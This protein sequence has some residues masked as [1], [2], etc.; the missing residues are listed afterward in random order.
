MLSPS[1]ANGLIGWTNRPMPETIRALIVVLV[2]AVPAFYV[3]QQVSM[4]VVGPREFAIWGNAWFATTIVAFVTANFFIFAVYIVMLCV[5]LRVAKASSVGIYFLLLFAVPAVNISIGGFGIVNRLLDINNARLLSIVLLLPILLAASRSG[6]RSYALPDI[7]IVSYVLFVSILAVRNS[8]FTNV[9][10]VITVR[11]LDVL[12]PYFAFSR[13]VTNIN[14]FR[15]IMVALVVAVLPLTLAGVFEAV[16]SWRLYSSLGNQWAP[17]H[18]FGSYLRRADI[19]RAAVTAKNPIS[20]GFVFMTALGGMV[21]TRLYVRSR[22]IEYIAWALI[23]IGLITTV[24]R[25]PWAGAAVFAVVLVTTSRRATANLMRAAAVAGAIL[26]PLLLTPLGNFLPFVGSVG[27]ENVDYRQR[28]F[29][30]SIAVIS[31]NPWFGSPDYLQ[32]PEMQ[33]LMQGI[34]MIDVVNTYLAVALYSGLVGLGFFLAFFCSIFL[35]LRRV[36]KLRAIRYS[37]LDLYI[38]V[39][40]ATL[41]AMLVTIATVSSIDFVPYL[42]WS[43]AGL[44]VALIRIAD[45]EQSAMRMAQSQQL[46]A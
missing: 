35:G 11:V 12:I 17:I 36:R 8:E 28:L 43:F 31:R 4:K 44:S 13:A 2:L 9:M 39:A 34:G 6:R 20:M 46:A 32:A 21:V 19:L 33:P 45:K 22:R 1:F 23:I 5:Y 3:G 26:L 41:A 38:R 10:R 16:K 37:E 30:A 18:H 7:L 40:M 24:S 14:D 29:E 42:Y 25:G 15:K 27:A